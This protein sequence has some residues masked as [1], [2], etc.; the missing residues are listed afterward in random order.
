M[1]CSIK[2]SSRHVNLF[3]IW[4][5]GKESEIE[6]PFKDGW[7]KL[8]NHKRIQKWINKSNNKST[9]NE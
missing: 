1:A 4:C 5:D 2:R 6:F 9:A 3:A 8:K 7:K